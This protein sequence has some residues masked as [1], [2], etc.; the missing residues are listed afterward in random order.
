MTPFC[1]RETYGSLLDSGQIDRLRTHLLADLDRIDPG[2]ARGLWADLA[3]D[4][5]IGD[6]PAEETR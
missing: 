6:F 3:W 5:D 1:S 4:I 2:A